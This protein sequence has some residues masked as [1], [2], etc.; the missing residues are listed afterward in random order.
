MQSK[1]T[2]IGLLA[3]GILV[4][5][6]LMTGCVSSP[7]VYDESSSGKTVSLASGSTVTIRLKENPTTGYSWVATIPEGLTVVED[8]Y[9]PDTV[10]TGIVGSGGAHTWQLRSAIAGTYTFRG[11]YMQPWMNVT[12]SEQ[13][14][15]LTLV[16]Q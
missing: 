6:L 11:I 16:V 13:T 12:G 4:A 5:G 10:P 3:V 9:T 7:P 2:C 8:V 14:Y 15:T 1:Y